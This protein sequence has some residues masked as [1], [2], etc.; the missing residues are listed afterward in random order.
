MPRVRISWGD[1]MIDHW[2]SQP[3]RVEGRSLFVNGRAY[4]VSTHALEQLQARHLRLPDAIDVLR[5]GRRWFDTGAWHHAIGRREVIRHERAFPGIVRL[6]GLQVVAAPD[7]T[8]LT[9]Y[10][11]RT[12]VVKDDRKR[13]R[14]RAWEPGADHVFD[15]GFVMG[16]AARGAASYG[17]LR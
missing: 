10:R 12:L 1:A 15:A 2:L 17:A 7:G 13:S 16:A 9:A 3:T 14:R 11:N 4:L 8:I 6:E 5:F